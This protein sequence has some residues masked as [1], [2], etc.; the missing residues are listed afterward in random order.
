[1]ETADFIT[2]VDKETVL[3]VELADLLISVGNGNQ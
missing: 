2:T 3:T 1:M